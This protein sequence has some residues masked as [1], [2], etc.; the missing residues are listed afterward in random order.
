MTAPAIS[1]DLAGI[2]LSSPVLTASG[3]FG[4]G[5]E[6]SRFV[7]LTRLGAIVCKTVTLKP[8]R[9][10]APPRGAETP[11][12][13]LNAIGLQNPGVD[14]FIAKDLSWLDKRNVPAIASIG[15]QNVEEYVACAERLR[16]A[17]A[18]V[19]I[20]LNLSCPNLEDRGFMFALS[21]ERTAEV[22]AAVSEQAMVPV[23]AKLSPDVT[24]LVTIAD[25]AVKAGADGLSLIN[26]TLGMAIDT[27]TFRPKLSTGTGG[28]SGPAI[29][30]IAVRCIW[31]VHQ[32]MPH[33]PIIGMGGVA[34]AADA[35]ELILAGATAVAVGTANFYEPRA[36]ELVRLG[37]E[38]F[39]ET[40]GITRLDQIRGRVKVEG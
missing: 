30:P 25:A 40:N 3:C 6:M 12:G 21:A 38:R 39:L 19:A 26:T 32:A 1:I 20:E 15:G 5:Q 13:M 7:D 35:V 2:R 14:A 37:I 8:R 18:L 36:T 4:S 27:T 31:Q 16:E 33:V 10:I 17:P 22:C 23:F 24:D 11:S 28:L 9:G 34:S 29:R